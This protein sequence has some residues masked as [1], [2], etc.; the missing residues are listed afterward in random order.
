MVSFW[1]TIHV[2]GQMIPGPN[3]VHALHPRPPL[4]VLNLSGPIKFWKLAS[5]SYLH[6]FQ[7]R[8]DFLGVCVYV[9]ICKSYQKWTM[10]LKG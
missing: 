2:A 6:L 5:P 1:R 8:I 3:I 4:F 7:T 9:I 10:R